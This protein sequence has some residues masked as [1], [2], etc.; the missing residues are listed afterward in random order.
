[1]LING[2]TPRFGESYSDSRP[3]AFVAISPQASGKLLNDNSWAGL[4]RP[5]LFFSGDND[6]TRHGEESE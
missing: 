2:A 4:K 6:K 5:T 1:M 3:V